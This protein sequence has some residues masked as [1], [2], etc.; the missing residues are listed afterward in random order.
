MI[1]VST[2]IPDCDSHSPALLDLFFS[3]YT[4]I[5]SRM[6]FPLLGNSDHA[7]VLFSIDF[8]PNLQKHV[9]FHRIAYD[10]SRVDWDGLCDHLIDVPCEDIFKLSA[11]LLLVIFVSGFKLELIYIS[12]FVSI[13]SSLTH[14]HV[15]QPLELL[16]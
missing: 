3:S 6:A 8:P 15:F 2:R 1:D 5:C 10:Y 12:L 14:L 7:V 11:S 16:P 4:S 9:P 13:R